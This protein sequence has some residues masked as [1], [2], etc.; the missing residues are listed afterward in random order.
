MQ[1]TD[2]DGIT[3][4][5]VTRKQNVTVLALDPANNLV[6]A[7]TMAADK[8]HRVMIFYL[9]TQDVEMPATEAALKALDPSY[10]TYWGFTEMNNVKLTTAGKYALL[11][12]YTDANGGKATVL[13]QISVTTMELDENNKVVINE[14]DTAK[15]NHR[16]FVYYLGDQ[17]VE[18]TTDE[19]A[20]KAL[21]PSYKQYWGLSQMNNATLTEEGNYVLLMYY[22]AANGSKV[23]QAIQVT[24]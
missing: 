7:D 10:K 21:D 3:K 9:G 19:A 14:V 20:L 12:Y 16:M 8:N 4:V 1:F 22:T 15:T 11:M 18:N 23:A 13:R 5:T 24:I 17:T 6:A 2:S